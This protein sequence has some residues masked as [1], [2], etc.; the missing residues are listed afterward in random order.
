VTDHGV[1]FGIKEF[2][3]KVSK[4]NSKPLGI[5]KDSEKRWMPVRP[6]RNTG[7]VRVNE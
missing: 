7:Y 5:I 2:F 1:M 3:N 4:K 6:A